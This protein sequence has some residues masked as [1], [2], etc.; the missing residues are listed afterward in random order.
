MSRRG[1]GIVAMKTALTALVLGALCALGALIAR[2]A[3]A[4]AQAADSKSVTARLGLVDVF[5]PKPV[6]DLAGASG[7]EGQALVQ[8][9]APASDELPRPKADPVSQYLVRVATFPVAALG[10]DTTAWFNAATPLASP[11][12]LAAGQP[13]SLLTALEGGVTYY[14]GLRSKDAAGLT[15]I[16]D[17]QTRGVA[18]QVAVG[19]KGIVGV[20]N[21]TAV[22]GAG[23]GEVGLVWS[24]PGAIGTFGPMEYEVRAST[25]GQISN[26]GDFE[27]ALPLSSFSP[28]A[29]GAPG[30]FGA[31]ETLTVTGLEPGATYYFA[32][33]AKDSGVPPFKGVWRRDQGGNFNPLNSAQAR[34]GPERPTA[35]TD[36]T[37]LPGAQVGQ[38]RVSW[39]APQNPSG[40]PLDRYVIVASSVS[41]AALGGDATAWFEQPD[42]TVTVKWPVLAAGATEF[43]DISF[44][45]NLGVRYYFGLKTVDRRGLSSLIDVAAASV[46]GQVNSLPRPVP[47]IINLTAV[48][49]STESGRIDLEWT[50]PDTTGMV[51]PLFYDVRASTVA[52]IE[53]NAA[54]L[55]AAPLSAFSQSLPPAVS[56]A[57]LSA[58][59]VTGLVPHTTYF[60]AIRTYDSNPLNVVTSEWVRD[61]TA[62]VNANNFAVAP[63][64]PNAPF[65]VTDLTALASGGVDT[66]TLSWTAPR[67]ANFA[68]IVS[69]DVRF[70]TFSAA[71]L[72][73]DATAWFTLAQSSPLPSALSPGASVAFTMTGLTGGVEYFFGVRAVDL[74]GEVSPV[75]HALD[76]ALPPAQVRGRPVGIAPV[77]DLVAQPDAVSGAV[78]LT[79]TTPARSQT[80][81]PERWLVRVST[82]GQIPDGAAFAAAAPLSAFSGTP[83]PAVGAAGA[84]VALTV[85]GLTPFT[86]YYFAAAVADASLPSSIVGRWVRDA[87]LN[88]QNFAVPSFEFREPDPVSDLTALPGTLSG[89]V[90]LEWTAPRNQNFV[91]ISSYT[92]RA[93]TF[94]PAALA[95]DA[96]AWFLAA[97]VSLVYYPAGAPGAREVLTVSGLNPGEEYFFGLR[98]FDAIGEAGHLD[99][100][101][102]PSHPAPLVTARPRGVGPV[103]DL[104]AAPGAGAGVVD[105]SWTAPFRVLPALPERYEVRVST[106]GQIADAAAFAAAR[107]L[108]AFTGSPVPAVGAGA[109]RQTLTLTGLTPFVTYYFALRVSDSSAPVANAGLWLRDTLLARNTANASVPS[110]FHN[111]PEPVTDLTARVG[112]L[113]GE[114]A[115]SWTAPRNINLMP[116]TAYRVKYATV[117]VA[118]LAGDATAWFD[119]APFSLEFAS[120][121]PPGAAVGATV[122]GLHPL[123]TFYFAVRSVDAV[124]EVSFV[125]RGADPSAAE[126]QAS[127]R[128]L[129]LPPGAPAGFAAAAGLRRAALSWNDLPATVDGTGKGLDFA[130]YRVQRSTDGGAQFVDVTTT[131]AVSFTDRPL[132]AE[133]TALWRLSARDLEGRES[134]VVTVSTLPYTLAPLDPFGVKFDR[135]ASS[136]TLSWGRTQRFADLSEFF[137]IGAPATDEL[138]GYRVLRSTGGPF[139]AAA[140]Y[141][142]ATTTHTELDDGNSYQ[143][144]VVA[145]NDYFVSRGAITF[146][147]LGEQSIV[148]SDGITRLVV[149]AGLGEAL[150]AGNNGLNQDVWI[151]ASFLSELNGGEV[152]QTV[153]FVPMLGAGTRLQNFSLPKAVNVVLAFSVDGDGNPVPATAQSLAAATA[154]RVEKGGGVGLA[155]VPSGVETAARPAAAASVQHLGMYWND[156]TEFKKLYGTVDTTQNAV[157][158]Q[159]PNL[160]QFQVRRVFRDAAATFDISNI[161]T[162]V[163]TPNGDGKNDVMLMIFDN[164]RRAPVSGKVYDLRGA[165][166]ATM[167]P[168]LAADTLQWDGKMNGKP[169][170]SGVYIYQVEGDGKVFNGTVVVAR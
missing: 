76:P 4:A 55:A 117:P 121:A 133:T 95:G 143:Y 128:P 104:V 94:S 41:L 40:V 140:T 82:V 159:T 155:A 146:S 58:M 163:L 12:P 134:P 116:V 37:A 127:T 2:P 74:F 118:A 167:A 71:D 132:R 26:N 81:L 47:P 98:A 69:Y 59:S 61:S 130:H 22:T 122:G 20:T 57:T 150:R 70:A 85:T 169:V 42:S 145:F 153:E 157:V 17:D 50:S 73:G 96:T 83:A 60:F 77:T 147:P 158:A 135:T 15:S 106:A 119:A 126:V 154:G 33:R 46:S 131:S 5:R 38:I 166:V 144:R 114:V 103:T 39:T 160:G 111:L 101:L 156:G 97:P 161:T 1:P 7:G 136:I 19:V 31:L 65:A 102:D 92:V 87:Q 63:R 113:E 14:F 68:P 35:V 8:W 124:G 16:D 43:A 80:V 51:P 90:R 108:T 52:N 99:L 107:P 142:V 72:G 151:Q 110:F 30:A 27:S 13:Q 125:D 36:L 129:N 123:S 56:S 137:D 86:T 141:G 152:L 34:F 9:T 67:N 32:L 3:P 139:T 79:W 29:P 84:P 54:F 66:L 49:V 23:L 115:L 148:L 78:D 10:G 25:L 109:S 91:P 170:T 11:V 138:A 93:A 18:T 120:A 6:N 112:A 89:E 44:L 165:Y 100:G 88:P 24:A 62:G 45:G 64:V 48:A 149:P 75:D 162:R 168:G 28:S 105:L 21:L 164:P 53:D